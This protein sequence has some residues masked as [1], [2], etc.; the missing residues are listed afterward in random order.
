[1]SAA[2]LATSVPKQARRAPAHI[3]VVSSPH[4]C[5]QFPR[6]LLLA[7]AVLHLLPTGT[8]SACTLCV[9]RE[10]PRAPS[11]PMGYP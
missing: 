3:R 8:P 10:P 7:S 2:S 9:D 6:F 5:V 4:T 1:M 11:M